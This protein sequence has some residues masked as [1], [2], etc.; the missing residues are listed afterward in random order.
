MVVTR[1]V[2]RGLTQNKALIGNWEAWRCGM[3]GLGLK[4]AVW[5]GFAGLFFG[6]GLGGVRY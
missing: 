1:R 2:L 4:G 5:I 3:L 6:M